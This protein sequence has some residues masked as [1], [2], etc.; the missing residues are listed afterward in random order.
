MLGRAANGVFWMARYLERAGGT[1]RLM[2]INLLYL[3]EAEEDMGEEDKWRPILQITSTEPLFA[4]QYGD[5]GISTA[6]VLQF[7]SAGR[8][9]ANSNTASTN[10][11]THFSTTSCYPSS[12]TSTGANIGLG[13]S[14]AN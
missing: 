2:G 3:I 5:T 10:S 1:A 4:E 8:T 9:N 12:S 7:I 13:F 14:T 11:N 6:R